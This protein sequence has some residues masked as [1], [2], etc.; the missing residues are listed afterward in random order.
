[1]SF[2]YTHG[3]HDIKKLITEEIISLYSLLRIQGLGVYFL[4]RGFEG[5]RLRCRSCLGIDAGLPYIDF[6]I[7]IL[8]F[9]FYVVDLIFGK[10]SLLGRRHVSDERFDLIFERLIF[11]QEDLPD[12]IIDI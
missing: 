6:R 5:W 9:A 12:G 7:D 11:Y 8:E 2:S 1:M 10:P 3:K 4:C